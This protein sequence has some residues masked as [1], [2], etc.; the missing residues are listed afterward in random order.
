MTYVILA[1]VLMM[2][3]RVCRYMRFQKNR[4]REWEYYG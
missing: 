2:V 3:I 4:R 1:A